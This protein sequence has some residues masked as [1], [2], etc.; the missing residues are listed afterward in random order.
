MTDYQFPLQQALFSA[1]SAALSCSVYDDVEA[2][3]DL[4]YCQIDAQAAAP[5]DALVETGAETFFYLSFWSSYEGQMEVLSL[6]AEAYTALHRQKLT[7][8]V[9]TFVDMR[10]TAQAT[11]RDTDE[12]TYTGKMTVKV[13]VRH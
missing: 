4:P 13:M 12:K 5:F 9:G 2:G 8:S 1:L 10:V 3:A 11:V 6:M 7:L